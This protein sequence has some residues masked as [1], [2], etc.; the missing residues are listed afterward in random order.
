MLLTSFL[1][2]PILPLDNRCLL[3][4]ELSPQTAQRF[5]IALS[6]QQQSPSTACKPIKTNTALIRKIHQLELIQ[7]R[8]QRLRTLHPTLGVVQFLR[9]QIPC[10]TAGH[11]TPRKFF[12]NFLKMPCTNNLYIQVIQ[13]IDAQSNRE[14]SLGLRERK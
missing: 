3:V 13:Q 2:P 11:T 1:P 9:T 4:A 5:T 7:R 12:E 6:Q 8:P 10:Y 14:R